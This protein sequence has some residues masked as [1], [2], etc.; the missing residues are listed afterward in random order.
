MRMNNN[1]PIPVVDATRTSVLGMVGAAIRTAIARLLF[2]IFGAPILMLVVYI[3]RA[4]LLLVVFEVGSFLVGGFFY[5]GPW[6]GWSPVAAFENGVDAN[7]VVLGSGVIAVRDMAACLVVGTHCGPSG[8]DPKPIFA[9]SPSSPSPAERQRQAA[10][11]EQ[12]AAGQRQRELHLPPQKHKSV[13]SGEALQEF[14]R[15]KGM[16]PQ[17]LAPK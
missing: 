10:Q 7:V 5:D 12:I 4:I 14:L 11:L 17:M 6:R 8:P 2:D 15:R 9:K 3:Y 13:M 1:F 16:P